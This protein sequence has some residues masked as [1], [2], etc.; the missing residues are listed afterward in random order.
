MKNDSSKPSSCSQT[1]RGVPGRGS[2][3]RCR[4]FA[5][6]RATSLRA[7]RV[8]TATSRGRRRE[9]DAKQTKL[10]GKRA[11]AR[12]GVA[13]RRDEVCA[14]RRDRPRGGRVRPRR[15]PS[16]SPTSSVSGL[17]RDHVLAGGGRAHPRAGCEAV[18]QGDQADAG[19]LVAE[20]LRAAVG[21]GV[22]TMT[23]YTSIRRTCR[24]AAKPGTPAAARVCTRRR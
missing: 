5:R 7:T 6:C 23:S 8:R 16:V 18:L 14:R 22:S 20:P 17:S 4:P 1:A 13:P 2:R 10:Q 24:I 3:S 19:R 9:A 15:H 21:Q 12:T 11:P